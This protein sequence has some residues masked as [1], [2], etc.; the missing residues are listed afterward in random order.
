MT[1]ILSIGEKIYFITFIDNASEYT[2]VFLLRIKDEAFEKF[3]TY[4]AIVENLPN[5]KIK[6]LRSG[7]RGKYMNFRFIKFYEDYGIN[8][9]YMNFE[10]VK[11]CEDYGINTDTSSP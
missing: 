8:T 9:E 10:F 6:V 2:Y 1:N 7:V 4:K 11:F 5:L 3:K